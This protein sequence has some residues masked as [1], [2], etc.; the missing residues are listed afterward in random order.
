MSS[1][2]NALKKIFLT[3]ISLVITLSLVC[4][5]SACVKEDP[6]VIHYIDEYHFESISFAVVG[7]KP[8]GHTSWN[9]AYKNIEDVLSVNDDRYDATLYAKNIYD[10][11]GAIMTMYD[12]NRV[13]FDCNGE[14]QEFA[15]KNDKGKKLSNYSFSDEIRQNEDFEFYRIQV[16]YE[17]RRMKLDVKQYLAGENFYVSIHINCALKNQ[18]TEI[19]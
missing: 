7:D 9:V 5:L 12:Y 15:L 3:I 11:Y 6:I 1:M 19:E 8:F 17:V 14:P 2:N 16:Q 18:K 13:V 4:G 10:K